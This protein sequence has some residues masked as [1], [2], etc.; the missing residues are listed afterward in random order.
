[1]AF[2]ASTYTV[3]ATAAD[4]QSSNA[5]ERFP[6]SITMLS[7]SKGLIAETDLNATASGTS[8]FRVQA[9]LTRRHQRKLRF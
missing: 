8:S 1:L 5:T 9:R 3:Q 4:H 6:F 7:P 2:T